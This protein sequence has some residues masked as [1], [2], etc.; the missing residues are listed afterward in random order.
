MGGH[1]YQHIYLIENEDLNLNAIFDANL[2]FISK[3]EGAIFV[4]D[5]DQYGNLYEL[6]FT[7]DTIFGRTRY[8]DQ[9]DGNILCWDNIS[10]TRHPNALKKIFLDSLK[11]SVFIL[12]DG[13]SDTLGTVSSLI[14]LIGSDT[15][16]SSR[17]VYTSGDVSED[18]QY[19]YKSDNHVCEELSF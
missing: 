4:K 10:V 12:Q 6:Y 16:T 3:N 8:I 15:L 14:K 5:I 1:L 17:R 13:R 7:R 9:L 19:Y 2:D 11:D 18:F